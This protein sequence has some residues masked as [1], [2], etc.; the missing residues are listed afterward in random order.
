[1]VYPVT[2]TF[3][4]SDA[5]YICASQTTASATDLLINGTGADANSA[6]LNNPRVWMAGSGFEH[7]VSITSAGTTSS[8]DFTITG[9]NVRGETVTE[10]IAGPNVG[11]VET[12]AFYN[13][14]SSVSVDGALGTAVT[15]G[16]GTTGRSQWYKVDYQISPMN[17]GIGVTPSG[18][19]LT[20]T[21]EQTTYNVEDGEP[22]DAAILVSSDGSMVSQTAARQ[23]NYVIPFGACRVTVD[24]STDGDL[25]VDI[26]QAG[27]T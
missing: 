6:A 8:I 26:Y 11:S 4:G 1:M 24:S 3:A 15:V 20:W 16:I 14:V 23:G 10:T 25:T 18:T 9:K 7:A 12:D 13:L 5:S 22:P 27:I 17:I 2:Y 21:L 19:D